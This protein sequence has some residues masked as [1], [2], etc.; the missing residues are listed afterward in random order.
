[1]TESRRCEVCQARSSGMLCDACSKSF[2]RST[3]S[4][5]GSIMAVIIW[6][7]R[8]ARYFERMNL[9]KGRSRA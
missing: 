9:K 4:D 1:M 3:E 8:R 5:D 6:A 2:D 7:A